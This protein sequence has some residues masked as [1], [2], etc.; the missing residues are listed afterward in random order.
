M[1]ENIVDQKYSRR[2][3]EWKAKCEGLHDVRQSL[4]RESFEMKSSCNESVESIADALVDFQ[5]QLVAKERAVNNAVEHKDDKILHCFL[6]GCLFIK[7]VTLACGHTLCKTCV[8]PGKTSVKLVECKEC[9]SSNHGNDI[10][11]NVLIA[12]LVRKW[13]PREYE[14][15]VKKLEEVK[16]ELQGNQEK[17]VE[18]LS[19][20]LRKTPHHVT[21][22]KWRSH[23][24]F[25]M[26]LFKQ[27]LEDAELACDLRPFFPSVLHQ[28]GVILFAMGNYEKAAQSFS[29]A[30]ALE[31]NLSAEWRLE[32]ISCLSNSLSY[33][34][35]NPRKEDLL[36]E[37]FKSFATTELSTYKCYSKLKAL[38]DYDAEDTQVELL[39]ELRN[40]TDTEGTGA[41]LNEP[42][43]LEKRSSQK[44]PFEDSGE[45]SSPLARD[46]KSKC[47]KVSAER[48]SISS[49]LSQAAQIRDEEDLECKICYCVFYQPVTTACGHTFCRECLQRTL[50]HRPEC[51]CCR[52]TL[53]CGV[54]RNTKVTRVVKNIVEK[55]FP[56]EY[57]EREKSFSEEKAR[58]KG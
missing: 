1:E 45:H 11:V 55:L 4:S 8:L 33:E 47:L 44:R 40:R 49:N 52:R 32:L 58:W 31:P 53:H 15:E 6:C 23:A 24:L 50:D 17:L 39:N 20:I 25:Q 57:A 38:N 12:D 37:R 48:E 34:S 14:E 16:R 41:P 56:E 54:E 19:G 9:G 36:A 18:T 10:T 42:D 28:R 43:F 30:V 27:A 29:R 13:F 21:A 26:G 5:R 3:T 51:P 2:S 35:E 22:L 7:P 46:T